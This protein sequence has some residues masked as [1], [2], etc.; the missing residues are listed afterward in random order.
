MRMGKCGSDTSV[1]APLGQGA[2]GKFLVLVFF[3]A[4]PTGKARSGGAHVRGCAAVGMR[5]KNSRPHIELESRRDFLSAF[6]ES[7]CSGV[8]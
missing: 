2:A 5:K 8:E 7:D 1:F 6:Q 3:E 4:P